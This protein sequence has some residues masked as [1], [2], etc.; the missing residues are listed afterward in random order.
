MHNVMLYV[1]HMFLI[2]ISQTYLNEN[3]GNR[4]FW[5]LYLRAIHH[6]DN[7]LRQKIALKVIQL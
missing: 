5:I 1:I 3:T 4:G 6:L 2:N 7:W